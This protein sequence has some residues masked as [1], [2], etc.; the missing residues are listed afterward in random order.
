MIAFSRQINLQSISRWYFKLEYAILPI[1]HLHSAKSRTY[2]FFLAKLFQIFPRIHESFD[3]QLTCALKFF[4]SSSSSEGIYMVHRYFDFSSQF[5][6]MT[7]E[8][9]A[10]KKAII[11]IYSNSFYNKFVIAIFQHLHS[12][13]TK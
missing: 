8:I 1:S 4:S 11:I 2:Y 6:A 3:V 13:S 12:H 10:K 7:T 9:K 5:I